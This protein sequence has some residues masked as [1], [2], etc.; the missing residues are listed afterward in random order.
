MLRSAVALCA[1][2]L[3]A[4]CGSP[5]SAPE[6]AESPETHAEGVIVLTPEQITAAGITLVRPHFGAGGTTIIVPA[7]LESEA[8]ATRIVAAPIEGRIVALT[9]N[10]GDAVARGDTLA[11]VESREAASLHAEVERA[12]TRAN[13]AHATRRRDE[14]L[15]AR[16]FRPLREVEITRAAA[17]EADTG[18]RLARQQAAAAGVSGGSLN[19]IAIV[20]PI[21]GR[22]IAREAMLGQTFNAENSGGPLFRVADL[23]R[24]SVAFSVSPADAA[25]MRAGAVV[26]VA[27]GD[28]RQQAR[29]RFVAPALDS[30]TRLVRV[31]ADLDNQSSLW[32]AGEPVQA[33][34]RVEAANGETVLMVPTA[35]VQTVEGRPVVFVRTANGFRAVP[36]RLG[37]REGKMTAVDEGLSGRE[38]IAADNSFVLKA[39][40]GKGEAGHDEH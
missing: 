27:A 5:A 32:R 38:T 7:I 21:A 20:S 28:R 14:A 23:R 35:A 2:L 31:I 33:A 3:I 11:I 18:L 12:R 34:V 39:E 29:V 6:P 22:I 25:R 13:L 1:A 16:G 10:L 24:L 15:Y 40:L 37:R 4:G 17:E 36:V 30:E 8:E 9:R 19:R 26:D